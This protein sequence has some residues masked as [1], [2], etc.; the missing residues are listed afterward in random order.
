MEKSGHEQLTTAEGTSC[1]ERGPSQPSDDRT[2]PA[3]SELSA[4][5]VCDLTATQRDVL[6]VVATLT[7]L[8]DECSPPL[9]CDIYDRLTAIRA[10]TSEINRSYTYQTLRWLENHD[11]VESS[12]S[13]SDGR[14][15]EYQPTN[16]GMA[17][18]DALATRYSQVATAQPGSIDNT[19]VPPFS[20]GRPGDDSES[21]NGHTGQTMRSDGGSV[22]PSS[23]P[24]VRSTRAYGVA[25]SLRNHLATTDGETI[26]LPDA[27]DLLTTTHGMCTDAVDARSEWFDLTH[28]DADQ[29]TCIA[30]TEAGIEAA[31]DDPYCDFTSC[32]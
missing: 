7:R 5:D 30:L 3:E 14:A 26:T 24:M 11:L 6:T 22:T 16:R 8:S 10:D 4:R 13:E 15:N 12:P 19:S 32:Q 2:S 20:L 18:L 29:P 17:V 31:S 27:A 25:K 1:L 21:G 23:A 9:G 28:V